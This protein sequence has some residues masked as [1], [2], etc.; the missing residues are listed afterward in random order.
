[1]ATLKKQQIWFILPLIAF[2]LA[3]ALFYTRLGKDTTVVT[4][5]S[6]NKQLPAL[7]LPSLGNPSE[8]IT[9]A[10]LPKEPYLVNVWASWCITCKV[11]HPFLLQMAKSGVPIVGIN[12][13][14]ET[15]DAL[16]YLNTHQDPYKISIVDT[17]DY[18]IDLGLT[19]TPESFVVD[20]QG[21]VR[22]HIIGEINEE[23]YKTRVLPC[24]TALR[25]KA[26]DAKIQEVCR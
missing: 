17:G 25:A 22:Q 23:R 20:G 26:D 15:K 14:D 8:I 12:Y 16:D 1:M 6:V 10:Q 5:T 4:N 13:K 24:I 7:K 3:I 18:G 11:E 19:G 9:N 21:N 2:L